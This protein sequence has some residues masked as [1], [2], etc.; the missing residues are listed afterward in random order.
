MPLTHEAPLRATLDALFFRDT[1]IARL[2]TLRDDELEEVF[3]RAPEQ[4][5][6]DHLERVLDFIQER[7]VGYSIAH[8]DGRCRL[9]PLLSRQQV[10][11]FEQEGARYL[12]DETTAVTRFIFPYADDRELERIRYLF[13]ALF[14]R[15]AIE[16]V[17]GEEQIWM[18][19]S[20]PQNRIHIWS[21]FDRSPR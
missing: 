18:I 13:G 21:A 10:S 17:K 15:S 11:T 3:P 4:G 5:D 7:F 2:R 1:L 12:V 9:G 6:W 16:V 20:G 14:V 19:E 8:V